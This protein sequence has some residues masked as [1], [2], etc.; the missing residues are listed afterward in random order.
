MFCQNKNMTEMH[1]SLIVEREQGL[2]EIWCNLQIE[3]IMK[4]AYIYNFLIQKYK[5]W[6]LNLVYDYEKSEMCWIFSIKFF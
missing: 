4:N 6:W 3:M 2:I 1:S 5:K